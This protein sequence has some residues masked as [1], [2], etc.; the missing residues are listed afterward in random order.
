[1]LRCFICKQE[2]HSIIPA[3]FMR[4][5]IQ[6]INK[7]FHTGIAAS[8]WINKSLAVTGSSHFLLHI[9][10]Q[11]SD[12]IFISARIVA[13]NPCQNTRLAKYQF[14]TVFFSSRYEAV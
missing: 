4:V 2:E 9:G 5:A 14:I 7:T 12:D 1:M 6:G 11:G 8:I 13:I 10:R 3:F